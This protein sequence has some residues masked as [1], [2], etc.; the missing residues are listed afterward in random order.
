MT[1]KTKKSKDMYLEREEKKTK[2]EG[3]K[4]REKEKPSSM[5]VCGSLKQMLEGISHKIYEEKLRYMKS[6]Q[7]ACTCVL[8]SLVPNL[9]NFI[10]KLQT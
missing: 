10:H 5:C 6:F 7:I 8:L 4:E 1:T 3:S 9:T 2:K